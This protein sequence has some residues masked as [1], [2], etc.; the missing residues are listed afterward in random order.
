MEHNNGDEKKEKKAKRVM[1]RE[2]KKKVKG[3]N[4]DY[5]SGIVDENGKLKRVYGDKEE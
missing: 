2:S 1:L 5:Y 4:Y 3:T